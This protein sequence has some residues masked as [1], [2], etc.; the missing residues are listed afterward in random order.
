LQ[1][2]NHVK[3]TRKPK[4][5]SSWR[6]KYKKGKKWWFQADHTV[7]QWDASWRSKNVTR[8]GVELWPFLIL[9]KSFVKTNN[10]RQ[11]FL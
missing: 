7:S 8:G 9:L 4:E 11:Y 2:Q 1:D 10:S 3:S 5:K 6:K